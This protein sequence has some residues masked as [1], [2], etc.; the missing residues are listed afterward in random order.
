MSKKSITMILALFLAAATWELQADSLREELVNS[1]CES[2][3][4][5][6]GFEY[7][8]GVA[9]ADLNNSSGPSPYSDFTSLVTHIMHEGTVK[10]SLTPG[11]AGISWKENWKIWI[12]YNDDQDFDD[13]GEEV[14]SAYDAGTVTGSF[15]V[16]TSTI[17]GNTRM[18]VSMKYDG[19]Q[20]PCDWFYWGEVEDYTVN[21]T[22]ASPT[23]TVLSPNGGETWQ[24]GSFHTITWYGIEL[25]ANL[26]I[27]LWKNGKLV[28]IIADHVAPAQGSY[29]WLVGKYKGGTAPVGAGYTIKIK[30][31]GTTVAD[32]SDA[33]FTIS[34]MSVITIKSPNGGE[35]WQLGS[36]HNIDW[37]APEN[38]ANLKITL[39]KN[40]KL[41]GTI[42]DNIA[43]A[44]HSYTWTVGQY[45]GGTAPV[46]KG[47]AIK[48]KETG[49]PVSDM[50]NATFSITN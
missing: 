36:I 31:N 44:L 19:W 34:P 27:T 48:I 12:D 5:S 20:S 21:I 40:G 18:R 26:K 23:V 47:Y 32:I 10:V 30:Q 17:I 28:G 22:E 8:A 45:N 38:L 11:Y 14:F 2:S 29:K 43:P 25:S 15:T 4:S 50:S 33:S 37:I 16:P 7:I 1:Y 35:Y 41:V 13:A 49:T 42:A 6:Q 9:V 39:W 3:A 46:K 24:L